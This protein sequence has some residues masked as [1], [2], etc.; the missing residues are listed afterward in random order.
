MKNFVECQN[1]NFGGAEYCTFSM[2]RNT[3]FGFVCIVTSFDFVSHVA[4]N[5]VEEYT[6]LI[7]SDDFMADMYKELEELN[8]GE[9]TNI[10]DE[11]WVRCW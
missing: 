11:I 7:S 1:D 2:E 4:F 10:G 6:K 8:V 9:S 3:K 5:S